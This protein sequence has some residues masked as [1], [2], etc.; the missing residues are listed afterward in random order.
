MYDAAWHLVG[1]TIYH[2][3]R[4]D[5]QNLLC[6]AFIEG[7]RMTLMGMEDANILNTPN[8]Q[9][10]AM[11][12]IP[13]KAFNSPTIAIKGVRRYD[14]WEHNET[15]KQ[16]FIQ[17]FAFNTITDQMDVIYE[18]LYKCDIP[19]FTRQIDGHEKSFLNRFTRLTG[20]R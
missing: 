15:K 2:N 9:E 11:P 13:D 5:F 7:M 6:I 3:Q 17:G 16:Y 19:Q 10:P 12:S 1:P 14:I 18:P 4:A 20:P 8:T